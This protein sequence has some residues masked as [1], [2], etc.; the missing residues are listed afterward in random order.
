MCSPTIVGENATI[1]NCRGIVR[2]GLI[3]KADVIDYL[4]CDCYGGSMDNGGEERDERGE[5]EREGRK[6]RRGRKT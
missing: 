2:M 6:G 3:Y 4:L 1:R 5:D